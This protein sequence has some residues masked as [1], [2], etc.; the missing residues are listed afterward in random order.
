MRSITNCSESG[1]GAEAGSLL[2][3]GVKSYWQDLWACIQCEIMKI[4]ASLIAVVMTPILAGFTGCES[5]YVEAHSDR[6]AYYASRPAYYGV[7]PAYSGA[8]VVYYGGER[9]YD[10][11]RPGYNNYNNDVR[12]EKHREVNN[13]TVVN[14]TSV[15]KKKNV[16]YNDSQINKKKNVNNSNTQVNKK[17][18]VVVESPEE[19]K[20]KG[21]GKK[22]N[23]Q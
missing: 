17:K 3:H 5:V 13:T 19:K 18:K 8:R 15:V 6:P 11:R 20:T 22:K 23:N 2:L 16:T 1:P 9:Y 4:T 14:N 10:N 7:R 21:K 12:V